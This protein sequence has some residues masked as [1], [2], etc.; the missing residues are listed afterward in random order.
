[1]VVNADFLS[2]LSKFQL[3]P[4]SAITQA[5]ENAREC[6]GRFNATTLRIDG[7]RRM[8]E[9]WDI[10]DEDIEWF[11]IS[12]DGEGCYDLLTALNLGHNKDD[13]HDASAIN[14]N[15]NNVKLGNFG[16]GLKNVLNKLGDEAFIF[17]IP[18]EADNFMAGCVFH[19]FL[20]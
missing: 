17:S 14:N 20:Q 16:A 13:N 11:I 7:P 2:A 3:S 1:M 4:F 5:V 12:D 9:E 6:G 15:N 8:S 19:S 18:R 10:V